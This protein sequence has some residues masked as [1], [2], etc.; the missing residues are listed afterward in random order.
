MSSTDIKDYYRRAWGL[1]DRPGFKYGGSYG[2]WMVNFS[3]Q[4]TFEEYLQDDNINKKPHFLDRK[5]EGGRIGQLV[6]PSVDGSRP[7]Y[8]GVYKRQD[9]PGHQPKWRVQGERGGVNV[10]KWLKSQG[11]E[12]TYTNKTEANKAYQKFLKAHPETKGEK[13][14]ATWMAEGEGLAKKYNAIVE[15]DFKTGDMS[16]TPAWETFLKNQKLKHAGIDH[17]KSNRVNVGAVNIAPMKRQLVDSLI[18]T[19]NKKLNHTDW[20]DIQKKVSISPDINTSQW[21]EYINK[22]DTRTQ[23][24]NKAFDHLL[25][26]D[27]ALKIPKNLSKTMEQGGSLLRKVISDITGVNSNKIIRNGL[28]SNKN[29][30][31]KIEQIK[32][33]NQGNLWSQGEGRTLN[34]ILNDAAYRMSG[35]ISWSSDIEKLAGRPNKNAFD[36]ALRHFNYHG[37]NKTGKSQI[38]FYYKGD[39]EMKKPIQWD[40][41][42]WDNKGGKKLKAS[43][44]FFVDST[45]RNKTQWTTE[46][47]DSDHKNWKDKKPTSGLFDELYQARNVYDDLLNTPVNDPRN[48]KGEKVKFGKIMKE[49]YNIGYDDL[50][51]VF[52]IDHGDG[53]AKS[54]WKNLR[55][56]EARI[57]SALYNITRKKGISESD[58]KKII[59]KLNQ[60]VY[61]PSSKKVIPQIIADQ[62][63][64]IS[65]VLVKGKKQ[66]KSVIDKIFKDLGINLSENQKVKAQSFLRNAMNKGQNIFKFVP[67]KVVRKGGGAAL[68]VLDYSLF[69]HLFG[70]PQTEAL[71]AAGGWLTKN[72]LLGKQIV[73][74]SGTVGIMEQDNP[75]NI[76]ELIGLPGPYKEDDTFM[77]DRMKGGEESMNWAVDLKEKMKVPE[78]KEVEA[79]GVDKYLNL[80]NQ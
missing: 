4:M 37:K 62:E 33:A 63:R 12:T 78:K 25:K 51:N 6:T 16:K 39:T 23:K 8:S 9:K 60:S 21:R 49:V 22:L 55:I 76:S 24:V 35:N 19:A 11:I 42:E 50:G 40:E 36:Y 20:M 66:D 2:D 80:T 75:T 46:K 68:A 3:D 30:I 61:S 14:K 74:T 77:V 43:E 17:Y 45:D 71:I 69:H 59:N 10:G 29:Y 56:A 67:N 72:D 13:T 47:I 48:P 65:D 27:V 79:T 38:Q 26:N 44:V 64:V 18:E 54:P 5:A 1:K 70:V 34:Q 15:K 53:V 31:D 32:F 7:G 52:G 41:I 28:D 57:N 58:R 73:A